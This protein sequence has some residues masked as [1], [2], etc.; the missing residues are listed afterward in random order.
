M[1]KIS[2]TEKSGFTLVEVLVGMAIFAFVLLGVLSM[3]G[4]H[5][6]SNYISKNNTKAIQ[7]AEDGIEQMKSVDYSTSMMSFNGIVNDFGEIPN[8][9]IFRRSYSVTPFSDYSV[10]QVSVVWRTQG[11]DSRPIVIKSIRSAN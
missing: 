10:I 5:I 9:P 3:I 4:A 1:K 11:T 7:L 6:H 2:H 8:Y